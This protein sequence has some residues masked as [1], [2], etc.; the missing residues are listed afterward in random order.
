MENAT[1]ALE[2]AGGVL[3]SLIILGALVMG[4]NKIAELKRTE[5]K[6]SEEA[7]SA[8]FNKDYEA[9]NTSSVYGSEIFSLANKVADYN[10]R[11]PEE[12][13]YVPIV[14]SV[15]LKK[16]YDSFFQKNIMYDAIELTQRHEQLANKIKTEGSKKLTTSAGITK[17]VQEWAKVSNVTLRQHFGT[18]SNEYTAIISY[19]QLTTTQNDIAR[20]TFKCI[21]FE[22]DSNGR[23]KKM[24]FEEN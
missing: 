7:Q 22:N 9:Y 16:D 13:G 3:F 11:Y 10:K 21:S 1:K 4:Y 17:T 20:T 6:A 24:S 8:N 14:L 23:I 5:Y 15:K 19:K 2:I 12:D 18:T